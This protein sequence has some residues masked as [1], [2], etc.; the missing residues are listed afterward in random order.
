MPKRKS[1]TTPAVMATLSSVEEALN[2]V[3]SSTLNLAPTATAVELPAEPEPQPA[4]RKSQKT[5]RVH[6][7]MDMDPTDSNYVFCQCLKSAGGG[8]CGA[9]L[10]NRGSCSALWTH[11]KTKHPSTHASLVLGDNKADIQTAEETL[12]STAQLKL[13]VPYQQLVYT[14]SCAPAHI[15]SAAIESLQRASEQRSRAA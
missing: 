1:T 11:V 9:R 5:A 14:L 7:V 6:E 4:S 2:M 15:L 13:N 12:A 3:D 10:K 8:V